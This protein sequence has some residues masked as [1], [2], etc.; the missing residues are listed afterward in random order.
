[1]LI[2]AWLLQKQKQKALQE[3]TSHTPVYS[4]ALLE[5]DQQS[6]SR[7]LINLDGN[8]KAFRSQHK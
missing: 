4:V 3:K 5:E 1:M 7:P 2:G 6:D 8:R